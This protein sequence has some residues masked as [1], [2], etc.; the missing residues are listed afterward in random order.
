MKLWILRPTGYND[1]HPDNWTPWYDKAFGFIIS[2]VTEERA[3]RIA[4]E[5]AGDEGEDAWLN[6]NTSSCKELIVSDQE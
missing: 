5:N 6:A 1:E 4:A 3:R 2:T